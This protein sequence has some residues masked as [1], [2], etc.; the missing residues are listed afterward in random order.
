MLFKIGGKMKRII[1][2][3]RHLSIFSSPSP[4]NAYI[5]EIKRAT[6][7]KSAE[8]KISIPDDFAAKLISDNFKS[9][10]EPFDITSLRFEYDE[11]N[12]G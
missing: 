12:K 3:G 10:S 2:I 11:K 1:S 7:R 9:L 4:I 6:K 5:L 8:I